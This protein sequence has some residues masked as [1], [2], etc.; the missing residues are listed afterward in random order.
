MQQLLRRHLF[1]ACLFAVAVSAA[2]LAMFLAAGPAAPFKSVEFDLAEL[3]PN[4]EQG[5]Y[6]IPASGTSK[7]SLSLTPSTITQGNLTTINW[8]W[9]N[10]ESAQLTHM[11]LKRDGVYVGV[12]PRGGSLGSMLSPGEY[13]YTVYNDIADGDHDGDG[14]GGWVYV[15][16]DAT[17]TVTTPAT[18][19]VCSSFSA[20]PSTITSGDSSTLTW[21]ST[22]ASSASINQSIG[23]VSTSGSRDVSPTATTTYTLSLGNTAG[24]T[25]CKSTVKVTPAVS[26]LPDLTSDNLAIQGGATSMTQGQSYIFTADAVNIGD[27]AA[28]SF[29][30]RFAYGW[31]GSGGSFTTMSLTITHSGGLTPDASATDTSPAL[32]PATSGTITIRHC[33]DFANEVPTESDETNNCSYRDYQVNGDVTASCSASPADIDEG[34]S[35][36]WTATASGG[37]LPYTYAWTGTNSLSGSTN[38]IS[39]TYS[40]SGIKTA[41]VTVTDSLGLSSGAVSCSNSVDVTDTS[42]TADIK[43]R[44]VGSGATWSNGPITIAATEEVELKWTSTNATSCTGDTY[45]STGTAISG[46]TSTVSEPTAGNSRTYRVTC[47]KSGESDDDTVQVTRAGPTSPP[48]LTAVPDRV[49][50]GETTTL[51]GNTNGH[52]SCEITG[53]TTDINI[54]DGTGAYSYTSD[55]IL[56]ET[57]FVLE[58]ALDSAEDTV[59]ILP[60]IEHI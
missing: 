19:P 43:A 47:S 35:S 58:C 31:G 45:Y 32:V 41:T 48:T 33:V 11:Y 39:K 29:R 9:D 21:A 60:A 53:G 22:G 52:T 1:V 34:E 2:S 50:Q 8:S 26:S 51:S 37:T 40:T 55:A 15:D 30:D 4:G 10:P 28:G 6:A 7:C 25:T 20:S 42:P 23:S 54:P 5:G 14:F 12:I 24:T 49:R 27:A 17:L 59:R 18:P 46:N 38:P 3:S 56:G 13:V 44:A 16:C 36:T 57:L